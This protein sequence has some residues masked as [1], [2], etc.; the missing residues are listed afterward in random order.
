MY[1]FMRL[2]D[3]APV[4]LTFG[5]RTL[6]RLARTCF[7][8][9][10]CTLA[11]NFSRW[12]TAEQFLRDE[13]A[14]TLFL[15]HVLAATDKLS[16]HEEVR[17]FNATFEM[18]QPVGWESTARRVDF[19]PHQ[20]EEFTPPPTEFALQPSWKGLRV[21]LS[22]G[23]LAPPTR[24]VTVIYRLAFEPH[25]WGVEVM[26]TYPGQ[27]LGRLLGNVTERTGR[28]FFPFDHPGA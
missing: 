4:H 23:I 5:E 16:V 8:G 15:G 6:A 25:G 27:H 19:R 28:V 11:G 9:R 22:S 17:K 20:L 26:S 1:R 7:R 12:E 10:E 13:D 2:S 14:M 3:G 24:T 21:K 18:S